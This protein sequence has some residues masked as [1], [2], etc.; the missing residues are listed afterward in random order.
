LHDIPYL[1]VSRSEDSNYIFTHTQWLNYTKTT[2]CL[3]S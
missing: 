1:C 2:R 3:E